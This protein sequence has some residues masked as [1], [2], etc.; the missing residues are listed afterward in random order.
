MSKTKAQRKQK[1][2]TPY[3][4]LTCKVAAVWT[5]VSSE[6]QEKTN[7]SLNT[8]REA[9]EEYA[10]KHGIR[11]KSYFGGTHESAKSEGSK[12]KQMVREVLRDKEINVILVRTFDRFGRAGAETILVKEEL[13]RHGVYV[14]SATEPCEPDSQ[15]GIVMQNFMDL[16]SQMENN[17]RRDKT[18]SGTVA[19]LNRGEWCLHVPLGYTRLGK[20]AGH[21]NIVVN[22]IGKKLRN[23]WIWRASGDREVDILVKLKSLGIDMNKQHLSKILMNPFYTGWIVH[24]LVEGRRIRG[25][26]EVLIDEDTFNR[27]NGFSRAGYEH[28]D[29]TDEYPLKRFVRCSTCGGFLTGYEVRA[30]HRFYYKCN[31]K[32]CCANYSV[33]YLHRKFIELLEQYSIPE[34]LLPMVSEKMMNIMIHINQDRKQ[35]VSILNQSLKET[36]KKIS[37]VKYKYGLGEIEKDI[38]QETLS[39]LVMDKANIERNINLVDEKLSNISKTLP[40]VLLFFCNIG[41]YWQR[42]DFAAR[43]K[44]QK[45]LFPAPIC[46][47]KGTGDYRT[48]EVNALAEVIRDITTGYG[49]EHTKSDCDFHHQSLVVEKRRLERPT[50]TSRTWCATN[51]A[52]SRC[53]SVHLKSGCKGTAF[54]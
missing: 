31:T 40:K 48:S 4:E 52:T 28:K 50:P 10:R 22:E 8:Q 3:N 45:M 1:K 16:F 46:Y 14:I 49:G 7:C 5:R 39:L 20:T 47:D 23:A 6:E 51:C 42:G 9:C 36:E 34:E 33:E 11:I 2:I 41:S 12:H 17:I 35:Q 26:H 25:N 24:E 44:L 13:K 15:M 37:V 32:G 54:F 30:R 29:V 43:Q 38:Y 53:L 18:F 27:A 19:S 21:H